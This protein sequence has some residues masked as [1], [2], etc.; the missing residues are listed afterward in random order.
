MVQRRHG[1]RIG[2]LAL[3]ALLSAC[4]PLGPAGEEDMRLTFEDRPEP[5]AFDRGG[6]AVRDAPD[7]AEGLWA[8]VAGLPRPERARIVNVDT[9]DEVVVALFAAGRGSGVDIRLS[10]EAAD[11]L[12]IA[13]RPTPVHVTALRRRPAINYNLW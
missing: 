8:A 13:D 7:G 1:R 4:G 3:T 2:A 12:G 5:A 9:G 6:L 11:A 10:N